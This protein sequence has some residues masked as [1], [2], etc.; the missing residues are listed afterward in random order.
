MANLYHTAMLDF[1]PASVDSY[2]SNLVA[3]LG[4]GEEK[5]P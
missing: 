5:L 1:E 2:I 4:V 3:E